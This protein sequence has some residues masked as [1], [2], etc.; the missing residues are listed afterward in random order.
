M[1][2]NEDIN[3]EC[4]HCTSIR[5]TKLRRYFFINHQTSW[6]SIIMQDSKGESVVNV[7]IDVSSTT[8]TGL[9]ASWWPLLARHPSNPL[10]EITI[11][12][13]P[14]KPVDHAVAKLVWLVLQTW[15]CWIRLL[16][17]WPHHRCSCG[18]CQQYPH[19][20]LWCHPQ[21]CSSHFW[22]PPS[23]PH[24]IPVARRRYSNSPHFVFALI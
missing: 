5:I 24:S 6:W 20:H 15:G 19:W 21:H 2:L 16:L 12:G 8:S 7:H 4:R 22:R 14:N 10:T 18:D 13:V 9:V 11:H 17:L 23:P 1:S 3:F